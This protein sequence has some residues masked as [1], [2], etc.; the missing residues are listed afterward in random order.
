ME[1]NYNKYK[2]KRRFIVDILDYSI[3]K[4]KKNG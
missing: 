1:G 2:D 4:I 3:K